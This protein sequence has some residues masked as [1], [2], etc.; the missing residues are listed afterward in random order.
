[1]RTPLAWK[2]LTHN[3]RR[4]AVALSGVAFAVIL[5]FMELGFLNALLESTV[6]VL[7]RLNGDIV[8]L[9]RAEYALIAAER[10]DIHRLATARAIPGVASVSPLYIETAALLRT[11]HDRGYPIRVLAIDENDP[12][13][14]LPAFTE[15]RDDLHAES[16]A[17][18]DTT[19]RRKFG[20]P[21]PSR[22][23]GP[24]RVWLPYEG[25]LNGKQLH[26]VGHFHL[27][28]DF[29]TDGN[30][31][32]TAANFARFAPYR[33]AGDDPLQL[34]DLG[35]IRLQPG[36]NI[37]AVLDELNKSLPPDVQA[38]SKQQLI[39]REKQFWQENAPLG[40]IFMV[41][42]VMGFVVGVVICYQIVYADISDHMREF[43]TL[44][45][46]GYGTTYFL[47]L[48]LE[49]SLY[50]ALLGFIPGLIISYGSYRF[51]AF[52]TGLTMQL[53]PN[54]A[55]FILLTTAAMC[56]LSGLLAVTK[57]LAT[58]PAELF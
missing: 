25:E 33:A 32:M 28:V 1:M 50:L 34:V 48:V 57:L 42:A 19:S 7:R 47:G 51:L 3:P 55:L 41:G 13:L 45:A 58:D 52:Y 12:A 8:L 29:A 10:F 49:Q 26:V 37:D 20:F 23:A 21:D 44:K 40:Y 39:D 11:G 14:D 53:T 54:L 27:G 4:L 22:V 35:I 56:T 46:I 18:F 9:S 5:I 38:V 2:N 36:V 15:H 17:L 43:A 31:L 24:E 6:Q 30:L 16:T